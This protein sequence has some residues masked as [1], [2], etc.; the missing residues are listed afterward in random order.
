MFGEFVLVLEKFIVVLV[1][2]CLCV[3]G[4]VILIFI[5]V[6]LGCVVEFGILFKGGE[7]LEVMYKIDMIFLDKMGIVINGIF[8]LI[9]VCIV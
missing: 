6:G 3:L 2:V 7:Y 4:L 1:I 5:M 8:E 9:D